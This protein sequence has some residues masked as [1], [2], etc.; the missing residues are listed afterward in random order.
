[1]NNDASIKPHIHWKL[2][3]AKF[4]LGAMAEQSRALF[5]GIRPSGFN[6]PNP[7]H[8]KGAQIFLFFFAGFLGAFGSTTYYMQTACEKSNNRWYAKKRQQAAESRS[9][10][11]AFA[12]LRN[13]DV[14]EKTLALGAGVQ[15]TWR[16]AQESTSSEF[17][18]NAESLRTIAAMNAAPWAAALLTQ[19]P[20]IQLASDALRELESVVMEGTSGGHL[21]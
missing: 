13:N 16:L 7:E 1:M 6:W 11:A 12:F 3:E 10:L 8:A 19:K 20:I 18:L 9:L 15:H 14:H 4:Y 17:V 2:L 5:A 21:R